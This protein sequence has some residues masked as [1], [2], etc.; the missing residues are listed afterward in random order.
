MFLFHLLNSM[1]LPHADILIIIR[2]V[3]SRSLCFYTVLA[4]TEVSVVMICLYKCDPPAILPRPSRL[5]LVMDGDNGNTTSTTGRLS[6]Y[7][8]LLLENL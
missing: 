2:N 5:L 8:E 3:F 7:R 4:S 6:V 1:S